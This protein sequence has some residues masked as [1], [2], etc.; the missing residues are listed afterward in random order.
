MT[1]M[2]EATSGG[3]KRSIDQVTGTEEAETNMEDVNNGIEENDETVYD[4][5]G[6][7]VVSQEAETDSEVCLLMLYLILLF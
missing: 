3:K 4:V 2:K 7:D 1:K 6:E 5:D